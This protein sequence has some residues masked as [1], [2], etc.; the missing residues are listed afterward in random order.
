[1]NNSDDKLSSINTTEKKSIPENNTELMYSNSN[2]IMTQTSIENRSVITNN[3]KLNHFLT[4]VPH[5]SDIN[6]P[7]SSLESLQ[8]EKASPDSGIQSQGE[9]PHRHQSISSDTEF[10]GMSASTSQLNSQ[11]NSRP[12]N[13]RKKQKNKQQS[14]TAKNDS[15]NTPSIIH[16]LSTLSTDPKSYRNESEFA[17]RSAELF[18]AANNVLPQS[19]S[20]PIAP[21]SSNLLQL[22]E[23]FL[24]NSNNS[25]TANI[26]LRVPLNLM[27][28]MNRNLLPYPRS[29]SSST[30]QP[31]MT[32]KREDDFE[33]L[34]RSIKD[35]IC[36]QFQTSEN[37]DLEFG[38]FNIS[39]S[40]DWRQTHRN[41]SVQSSSDSPAFN[42]RQ[43]KKN[44]ESHLNE[45][46]TSQI[47]TISKTN[48]SQYDKRN[49]LDK[50]YETSRDNQRKNR[51]KSRKTRNKSKQKVEKSLSSDS[52]ICS[53]S[54]EIQQNNSSSESNSRQLTVD[55]KKNCETSA[56]NCDELISREMSHISNSVTDDMSHTTQVSPIIPF[57][58]SKSSLKHVRRKHHRKH[59]SRH[60]EER[61][62]TNPEL[63][64]T[65]ENLNKSFKLLK[66]AKRITPNSN[67]SKSRHLLPTVFQVANFLK[68][69]KAKKHHLESCVNSSNDCNDSTKSTINKKTNKKKVNNSMNQTEQTV[70]KKVEKK[71]EVS[72][73]L[74]SVSSNG[75]N[76][77]NEQRLPLK[78]RHHR[79]IESKQTTNSSSIVTTT[80]TTTGGLSQ[81]Y[82]SPNQT[83][84]CS[85]TKSNTLPVVNHN[86]FN[87]STGDIVHD[88]KRKISSVNSLS[89][90]N[91]STVSPGIQVKNKKSSTHNSPKNSSFEGKSEATDSST[92]ST[93]G[94]TNGNSKL[95]TLRKQLQSKSA[96]SE[97]G[98]SS[99]AKLKKG[100]NSAASQVV[101]SS[102]HKRCVS[103]RSGASMSLWPITGNTLRSDRM[104]DSK[105]TVTPI[106][107]E[108]L[109]AQNSIDETI[110]QCIKKYS[111]NDNQFNKKFN[112]SKECNKRRKSDESFANKLS[113]DKNAKLN[114]FNSN[115]SNGCLSV[116]A[117]SHSNIANSYDIMKNKSETMGKSSSNRRQN[118]LN[119]CLN[120]RK[121]QQS[122]ANNKTKSDNHIDNQVSTDNNSKRL[123]QKQHESNA[124]KINERIAPKRKRSVNKT[125]FTK[126]RKRVRSDKQNPVKQ[127]LHQKPTHSTS[128]DSVVSQNEPKLSSPKN[129]KNSS[130]ESID[131]SKQNEKVLRI[132]SNNKRKSSKPQNKTDIAVNKLNLD[133]DESKR[134]NITNKKTD[135]IES[136][137][138]DKKLS[139]NN[140][141]S[142]KSAKCERRMSKASID[143]ISSTEA[144]MSEQS[145]VS[146]APV[147]MVTEPSVKQ[148]ADNNKKIHR[149]KSIQRSVPYKKY[150]KFGKYSDDY[151]SEKSNDS[152]DKSKD[153]SVDN[154]KIV[155]SNTKE[156]ETGPKEEV[157]AM[158]KLIQFPIC[159]NNDNNKFKERDD[160]VLTYDLWYQYQKN[161]SSNFSNPSIYKRIKTN[162]FVDV[163]PISKCPVQSCT[164]AKP[165]DSNNK[166]CG[167]DCL[168]RLMYQECSPQSCPCGE[169]CQNQRIQKHEWSPGLERFMTN[170]R[171]WGIRTTESIKCGDFILEYIGEVVSEQLFKHRMA[172]RYQNDQH[173]YCLNLDSGMVID[174]YRMGNEG[175]FV[176]HGCEPN[177]EMQKWSV[178]GVYRIGLFA[179]RDIMPN[180][181][182]SYD[183]NFHNFNLES[184][185]ICKCGSVRC[186]GY[187]GGRSQK[188][189][190]LLVKEK[191]DKNDNTKDASISKSSDECSRKRRKDI[192]HQTKSGTNCKTQSLQKP[193][194]LQPMKPL[195]YQQSCYILKHRCFLLRNYE[196]LRRFR[197]KKLILQEKQKLLSLQL[198]EEDFTKGKELKSDNDCFMTTLMAL[199]TTRSV[200][201][202]RLAKAESNEELTRTAK[203]A[204][205]F[206][207][208][209]DSLIRKQNDMNTELESVDS[210]RS[211]DTKSSNLTSVS[212]RK[213]T[214]TKSCHLDLSGIQSQIKCGF[215][216]SVESFESDFT[217]IFDSIANSDNVEN[218]SNAN[219]QYL[220][221]LKNEFQKIMSEKKPFIEDILS[222][223]DYNS[224]TSEQILTDRESPPIISNKLTS[225]LESSEPIE[226]KEIIPKISESNVASDSTT[227]QAFN[228]EKIDI[229]DE[230]KPI[231]K[232]DNKEDEEIIRCI[233]GILRDEGEMIQC[234]KCEVC[235]N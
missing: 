99:N 146:E 165:E 23:I 8:H 25:E 105:T 106:I 171:G 232:T 2:K 169:F 111:R 51:S 110:E 52:K 60:K 63:L 47:E 13:T 66:I 195:S 46:R 84:D 6:H 162:V 80:T 123:T 3:E 62:E 68:N 98:N 121:Q 227:V 9:S 150:L 119:K 219:D 210:N 209:C 215:Y 206:T 214:D 216:K 86:N 42:S 196:K 173:H 7:N 137:S 161:Q 81:L 192:M 50:D 132:K 167:H 233:C 142:S 164:C 1:M 19:S 187:I 141:N 181:E 231:I 207:D 152:S 22:T 224:N 124:N 149:I 107:C 85:D 198:K 201:T 191:N 44:N 220:L 95:D 170:E 179:L 20:A 71:C 82:A 182:L 75:S 30:H 27:P 183:Y 77:A 234:D 90:T 104:N 87:S 17:L 218:T 36:S 88:L 203:L 200:R 229:I 43:R 163:K 212:K 202:R 48:D 24:N 160:F 153:C 226:S 166:G 15:N 204:Q 189:N 14:K 120:V 100:S 128:N 126:P 139:L 144:Y 184:Q 225:N 222:S 208:V 168:N 89:A 26:D 40:S 78:K 11:Q 74:A 64:L 54:D 177:C 10:L 228:N 188:V 147:Y 32:Q 29:H 130:Q 112:I 133:S 194:L 45:A 55:N 157:K 92:K 67:D 58:S 129:D 73:Q 18:A 35:S 159:D 56:M 28:I 103:S 12:M 156:P 190:G 205:I 57:E 235:L 38:Q 101:L 59:H 155:K 16:S 109:K 172:E 96:K 221:Q 186:R 113:Y 41:T 143:S 122:S 134:T 140:M 174:G 102:D 213:N 79:H 34:V 135:Q 199:N 114:D 39:N 136:V 211:S 115:E 72:T 91:L 148:I 127:V 108:S 118:G 197:K 5:I 69:L 83:A 117:T 185:Q 217:K 4:S 180:E 158:T 61:I 145:S 97:I 131:K 65:M 151:K 76:G 33:L 116:S 94:I 31:F 230:K 138:V 37:D 193:L 176:N 125:G 21:N 154:Q 175:R 93:N 70:S 178:N 49:V 53:N 223:G